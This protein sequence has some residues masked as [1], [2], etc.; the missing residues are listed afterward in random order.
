MVKSFVDVNGVMVVVFQM[1]FF[2]KKI[3]FHPEHNLELDHLKF[4][5]SPICLGKHPR[6]VS[7][8]FF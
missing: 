4:K 5:C 1:N 7:T 8:L 3:I 2:V 6:L